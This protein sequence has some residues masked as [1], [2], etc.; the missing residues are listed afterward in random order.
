MVIIIDNIIMNYFLKEDFYP[1]S[2]KL[3][4]YEKCKPK[5]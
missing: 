3:S 5:S 2:F 4:T 1:S